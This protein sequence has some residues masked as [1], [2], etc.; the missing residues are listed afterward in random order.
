MLSESVLFITFI[1]WDYDDTSLEARKNEQRLLGTPR[2]G[3]QP[4]RS[5]IGRL[6][7]STLIGTTRFGATDY[8][9]SCMLGLPEIGKAMLLAGQPRNITFGQAL[10]L[11]YGPSCTSEVSWLFFRKCS[12]R[13]VAQSYH[14]LR[15]F[16]I[17]AARK[18]TRSR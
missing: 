4:L 16:G 17:V 18:S 8:L 6:F 1:F 9:V 11:H 3:P 7:T 15:H 12:S 2:R 10:L 13:T 14:L 5:G